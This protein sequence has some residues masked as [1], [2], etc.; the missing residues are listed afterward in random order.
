MQNNNNACCEPSKI[1][2][3][4]AAVIIAIG[5]VYLGILSWNAIKTHDYIGITAEQR[6]SITVTGEGEVVAAPDIAKIELGYIAEKKTVVQAQ[7]DN[8]DKM[9]AVIKKL[10]EDFKIDAKDIKTVNYNIT[11]SY[12]WYDGRRTLKGYQVSQN[13][14]VK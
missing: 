5:A 8:T 14:S 13:V 6:Y 9:N 4:F 11:P 12:D 1:L 3:I 10:K 7:K 2:T